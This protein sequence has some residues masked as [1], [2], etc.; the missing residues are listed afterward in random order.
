MVTKTQNAQKKFYSVSIIV[1]IYITS[2]LTK[3]HFCD[4]VSVTHKGGF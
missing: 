1:Y 4:F 2:I 3:T